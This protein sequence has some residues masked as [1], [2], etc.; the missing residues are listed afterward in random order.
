MERLQPRLPLQPPP[1][2]TAAQ[3]VTTALK[4]RT[5]AGAF[6]IKIN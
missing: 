5:P 1:K 3:V 4:Q 2:I 6:T